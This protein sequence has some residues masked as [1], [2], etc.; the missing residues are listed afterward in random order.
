MMNKKSVYYENLEFEHTRLREREREEKKVRPRTTVLQEHD[1]NQR[2]N[3]EMLGR[4]S[5]STLVSVVKGG[6]R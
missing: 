1:I 6:L 4:A 2:W 3:T 5:I